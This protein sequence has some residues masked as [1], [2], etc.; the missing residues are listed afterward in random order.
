MAD[1]SAKHKQINSIAHWQFNHFP[2]MH[3]M[4]INAPLPLNVR[5]LLELQS[6]YLYTISGDQSCCYWRDNLTCTLICNNRFIFSILFNYTNA[7]S[8]D[9]LSSSYKS[10]EVIMQSVSSTEHAVLVAAVSRNP[11]GQYRYKQSTKDSL[12][13]SKK[14][15]F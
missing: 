6:S 3:K 11:S 14:P 10:V 2:F 5:F 15:T 13:C 4:W 12:K 1:F 8:A 7:Q 9:G